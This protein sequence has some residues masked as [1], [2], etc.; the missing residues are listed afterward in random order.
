VSWQTLA[1]SGKKKVH[2]MEEETNVSNKNS[3]A[4]DPSPV[5]SMSPKQQS[6]YVGTLA[7]L[8]M[9]MHQ[10]TQQIAAKRCLLLVY[11]NI[12]MMWRVAEQIIGRTGEF[13]IMVS[14]AAC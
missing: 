10:L 13:P 12:N 11:D 4:Q 7:R 5:P 6:S 1:G 3:T 8:S 9:S 14:I 2:T